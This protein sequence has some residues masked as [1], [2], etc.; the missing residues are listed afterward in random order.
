MKVLGKI[1]LLTCLSK[2]YPSIEYMIRKFP[3]IIN[4]RVNGESP[5]KIAIERGDK[6]IINLLKSHGAEE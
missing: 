4:S 6:K 1:L 2:D 5:L 3:D